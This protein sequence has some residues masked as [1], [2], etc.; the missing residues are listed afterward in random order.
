[1]NELLLLLT[2]LISSAFVVAGWKLGKERLYTV[3]VVFLILIAA[4]GGKIVPILGYET[5]T[6]NIFYA[7]V[8]LATYFLIERYGRNEGIYSIW[9]GL[10]VVVF[11]TALARI[12]IM[13]TGS[14]T[15]EPLNAA[16]EVALAPIPRVALAS[17]VAYMV[18][19][20]V[21][22]YL[23]LYLKREFEERYL[24]FRANVSNLIAQS[25]DSAVFFTVAFVGVLPFASMIEAIRTGLLIKIVF[26][27]AA[28]SLLYLNKEQEERDAEGKMTVMLKF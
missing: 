11:F 28:S 9:V 4:V 1:M 10:F 16:L 12:T 18:S 13:F 24:W 20:T 7:S 23:Y 5:N 26:M 15:T 27:A 17:L 14:A 22:V 6:G 19:Q 3:I 25:I 21:N 2:A 8:F